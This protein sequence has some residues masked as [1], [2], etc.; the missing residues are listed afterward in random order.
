MEKERREDL[1]KAYDR[2]AALRDASESASWKLGERQSFFELLRDRGARSLL[3]IGPGPGSTAAWFR[4]QGLAVACADLSPE[5][6]RLCRDK[7][8][9]AEV[10]DATSL[11]FPDA[12]FDAVYT[13][14]CLLHLSKSELPS[15]LREMRRVLRPGGL[16]YVGMYGGR[17]HEGVWEGDDYDPKR[18]FSFHTDEAILD[19]VRAEFEVLSFERI[20][21]APEADLHFQ[22]MILETAAV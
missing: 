4:D 10:M 15:A 19:A 13:M 2:N 6:V 20:E 14:N 9:T 17:D 8:L 1:Q 5:N 16:A 7:D 21:L 11:E 3:E 12:S 22:S 18:F